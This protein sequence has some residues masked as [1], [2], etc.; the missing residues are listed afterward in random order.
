MSKFTDIDSATKAAA[1]FTL[2]ERIQAIVRPS[3]TL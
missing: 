3:G 2:K 1:D